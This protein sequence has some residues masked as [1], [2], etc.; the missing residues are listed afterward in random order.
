MP[1]TYDWNVGIDSARIVD[2]IDGTLYEVIIT[3][4]NG[5]TIEDAFLF[6]TTSVF[7]SSALELNSFP[8]PTRDYVFIE[9]EGINSK[10]ENLMILDKLG[11]QMAYGKVDVSTDMIR[12]DVA[13]FDAGTYFIQATIGEELYYQKIIV[14]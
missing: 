10:L 14:F 5:C 9:L 13:H 8:N 12:L 1:Y 11:R 7:Q 3:D 6:E 4:A 2:P